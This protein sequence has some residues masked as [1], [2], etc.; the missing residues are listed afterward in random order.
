MN[1]IPRV[2]CINDISGFGRCSLTTAIAI[3]SAA[4]VQACPVPTA[5]LSKHTGFS[6]FTFHDLT[7]DMTKYLDTWNDIPIDAVYS[8]FLGSSKQI[9]IVSDFIIK[10]RKTA[11]DVCVIID[12]VM[13]DAGR[14]Y[15]TYTNEMKMCMKELVSH[16]DIITPNLT[17]ACFLTETEYCGEDVEDSF[18]ERLAQRLAEIGCNKIVLTGIRHG[19]SMVNLTWDNGKVSIDEIHRLGVV[20]SG[21]GDIFASVVCAFTAKGHSL[22][23]C[24][25]AAGSFISDVIEHTLRLRSPVKDGVVFEP[26]LSEINKYIDAAEK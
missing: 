4:G 24:V 21:T 16:A 2:A 17:E 20:F 10:R 23:R 26:L 6:S 14:L 18:A 7:E 11:P 3:L 13:G 15:P 1:V 25:D 22:P 12:P 5:V 19:E 8:G 9:D